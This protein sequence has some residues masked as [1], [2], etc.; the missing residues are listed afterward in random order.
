MTRTLL[1]ISSLLLTVNCSV[2][3]QK[4]SEYGSDSTALTN[5]NMKHSWADASKFPETKVYKVDNDSKNRGKQLY[6]AHCDQCHGPQGKGDGALAATLKLKPADLSKIPKGTPH[7]YLVIQID[8]GKRSMP[9]WQNM[10]TTKQTWDL[11]QYVLTFSE[12]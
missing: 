7:S 9:S 3:T 8:N 12:K 4:T 5:E 6:M 1:I 10:L 11:T 2:K